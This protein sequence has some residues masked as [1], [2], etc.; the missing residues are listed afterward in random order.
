V[1]QA[2]KVAYGN[3]PVQ[4]ADRT[5]DRLL[6]R[7]CCRKRSH[8]SGAWRESHTLPMKSGGGVLLVSVLQL[9]VGLILLGIYEGYKAR[10]QL[11]GKTWEL[12]LPLPAPP[13][14]CCSAA[15]SMPSHAAGGRRNSWWPPRTPMM[16]LLRRRQMRVLL[17]RQSPATTKPPRQ[18]CLTSSGAPGGSLGRLPAC[19]PD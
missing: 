12:E 8:P 4:S 19:G 17:L 2:W 10:E 5:R 11:P 16:P 1:C 6:G 18:A 14:R 15:A 7:L 13:P 3:V 9:V